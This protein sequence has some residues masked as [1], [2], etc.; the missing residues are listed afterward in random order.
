VP[1]SGNE[2]M[3]TGSHDKARTHGFYYHGEITVAPVSAPIA[4]D[5]RQLADRSDR[6][7]RSDIGR[8]DRITTGYGSDNFASEF[9]GSCSLSEASI[10]IAE[11]PASKISRNRSSRDFPKY[12]IIYNVRLSQTL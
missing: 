1:S 9:H 4:D 8:I 3:T 7:D 11:T 5:F 10:R 6:S 2:F 12:P